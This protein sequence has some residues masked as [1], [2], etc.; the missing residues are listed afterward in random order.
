MFGKQTRQ[1]RRLQKILYFTALFRHTA[2]PGAENIR[3]FVKIVLIKFFN[4]ILQ[5]DNVQI[6]RYF[7]FLSN[8][9]DFR[10]NYLLDFA[11]ILIMLMFAEM[12]IR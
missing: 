4:K 12:R 5:T 7:V 6:V 10:K 9:F 3:Q 2:Q 1:P 11:F 8:Y